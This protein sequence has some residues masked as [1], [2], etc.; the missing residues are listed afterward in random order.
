MEISFYHL[1]FQ[2][3]NVALPKLLG[4]VLDVKMNDK[5]VK[6]T[7]VEIPFYDPKKKLASS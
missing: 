4:K 2:P 1:T 7:I 6:A 5:I 3:L